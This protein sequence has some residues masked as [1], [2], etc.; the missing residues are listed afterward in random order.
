MV[1]GVK[2]DEEGVVTHMR[3]EDA[4][5]QIGAS[6]G[7]TSYPTKIW[8]I[9]KYYQ[10]YREYRVVCEAEMYLAEFVTPRP[11]DPQLPKFKFE[12]VYT[13]IDWMVILDLY[14]FPSTVYLIFSAIIGFT[15]LLIVMTIRL[16][17]KCIGGTVVIPVPRLT[18]SSLG[19]A[20][21][22]SGWPAVR[23]FVLMFMPVFTMFMML[24]LF[25][26]QNGVSRY[27]L[28]KARGNQKSF[29][30]LDISTVDTFRQGRFGLAIVVI[31]VYILGTSTNALIPVRRSSNKDQATQFKRD[32]EWARSRVHL[33]M[34]GFIALNTYFIC[35]GKSE[36]FRD[37]SSF[38]NKIP[39]VP[40]PLVI[41]LIGTV[42]LTLVFQ[43]ALPDRLVN[44]PFKMA[45]DCL[46]KTL[47]LGTTKY[48]PFIITQIQLVIFNIIG[49]L[50]PPIM[51]RLKVKQQHRLDRFF[52]LMLR[53]ENAFRTS[54]RLKPKEPAAKKTRKHIE[55]NTSLV[56]DA[57]LYKSKASVLTVAQVF[58]IPFN[59]FILMFNQEIGMQTTYGNQDLL[60]MFMFFIFISGFQFIIDP[61]TENLLEFAFGWKLREF[62]VFAERNYRLRKSSWVLNLELS[63]LDRSGKKETL[64]IFE[65]R[66]VNLKNVYKMCFQDQYYFLSSFCTMGFVLTVYGLYIMVDKFYKSPSYWFLFDFPFGPIVMACTWGAC[67]VIH[68]GVV[69]GAQA[70]GIWTV[71]RGGPKDIPDY[72]SYALE[73]RLAEEA[74]AAEDDHLVEGKGGEDDLVNRQEKYLWRK[75]GRGDGFVDAFEKHVEALWLTAS[76]SADLLARL[77]HE[78]VHDDIMKSIEQSAGTVGHGIEKAEAARAARKSRKEQAE[79]ENELGAAAGAPGRRARMRTVKSAQ[80]GLA[81]DGEPAVSAKKIGSNQRASG[82]VERDASQSQLSWP[83]EWD[84]DS[85]DRYFG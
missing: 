39:F 20:L 85:V 5:D 25:I 32:R 23:G 51:E 19:A 60:F 47:T 21:S 48:I 68:R 63:E 53:I 9:L 64:E 55:R 72:A 29:V 65:T 12:F 8:L 43:V 78:Y 26:S 58:Q 52:A 40:A 59:I 67:F 76:G 15:V 84:N 13:A 16:L 42:M 77:M 41:K 69:M 57:V 61:V 11:D 50:L 30:G 49:L 4:P 10:K 18:C 81:P 46:V 82:P 66:E 31:G 37:E 34:S 1:P 6:P 14:A 71:D 62:A 45:Q 73:K 33:V 36:F 80:A 83:L 24:Y 17:F 54:V 27:L 7:A 3:G 38:I 56:V 79:K 28:D 70:F 74:A 35:F 2:T 22:L 75:L 44:A